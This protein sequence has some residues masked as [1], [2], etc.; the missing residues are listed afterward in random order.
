M[1]TALGETLQGNKRFQQVRPVY[2]KGG[3]IYF[4]ND[5]SEVVNEQ[6]HTYVAHVEG[7]NINHNVAPAKLA[8]GA[9][10][11]TDCHS[12]NAHMFKGGIVTSL[13][14]DAGKPEV[15]KS[16]KLIGCQ[17]WIF[18]INQI[19]QMYLTPYVSVGILFIAFF[20]VLHYTGQGPKVADFYNAPGEI[21][22][23]SLTERWTHL[24]RMASFG[25][26]VLTGFIFFYNSISLSDIFF[27]SSGAAVRFHWI[28]GLVFIAASVISIA[29]WAR[30]A[31]F[32]SYDK[33]WLKNHGGYI[34]GKE[35]YVP[36]GRMNA[37]QKIFFWLTVFLT[38]IMGATGAMLIFKNNLPL[39]L[40]CILSTVHGFFAI[41]FVAAIIAHAYLGT[42]ANP[43]TWRTLVDGKVS[44]SWAEKHHS[45][46]YKE[47][48]RKK[49]STREDDMS[50]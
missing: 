41:V 8:L 44:R 9:N 7:F 11:C 43:G 34:G 2:H 18:T 27:N 45:E 21:Q 39:G 22:R 37:G 29:L 10:G 20:L 42:I 50:K 6:D 17:P 30:D 28:V 23:F 3:R 26:L 40:S 5:G 12:E 31:R 14:N 1:L 48:S 36:A 32:A 19:H 49:D 33:E 47:I 4:L 16:G 46:W 25:L 38:V 13:F 35:V 15:T 24:F